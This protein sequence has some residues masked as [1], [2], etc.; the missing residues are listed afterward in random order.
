M[1]YEKNVLYDGVVCNITCKVYQLETR[2]FYISI[3]LVGQL[4]LK[5]K[6][7][8]KILSIFIVFHLGNG[9]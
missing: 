6:R 2:V 3:I 4:T 8:S 5:A 9:Q 7:I 1:N